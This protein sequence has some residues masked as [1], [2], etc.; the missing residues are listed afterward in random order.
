[1]LNRWQRGEINH[2]DVVDEAEAI[3]ESLWENV[4]TI[5]HVEKGDI[6]SI[7][8]AVLDLLSSAHISWV[9]PVDIPVLLKF[10]ETP[11][12]EEL[13]GWK[14]FDAYWEEMD[15]NARQ[16]E[17]NALYFEKSYSAE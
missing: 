10:L 5:P 9:M 16:Q 6:C 4:E 17:A 13:E 2:W 15:M 3:E 14:R 8:L 1:M 11:T 7:S 12:G